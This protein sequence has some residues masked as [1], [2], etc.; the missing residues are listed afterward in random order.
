MSSS[1]PANSRRTARECN[2]SAARWRTKVAILIETQYR[3]CF[4]A[5]SLERWGL[6]IV[7]SPR[8]SHTPL[9]PIEL[10]HTVLYLICV[11]FVW[12]V[13]IWSGIPERNRVQEGLGIFPKSQMRSL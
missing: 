13:S 7:I 1:N 5:G 3:I 9:F 6:T 8:S 11:Q 10:K 12:F 2:G 4:L